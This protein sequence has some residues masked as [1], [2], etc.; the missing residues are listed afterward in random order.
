MPIITDIKK[1]ETYITKDHSSICELMH[2][3]QHGNTKQ[4]LAQAIVA[5]HSETQLHYHAVTEEL[6][7]I[8]QGS[9]LMTIDDDQFPVTIGDTVCI[10]PKSHHKIKN[11]DSVD[12]VFL[13]CCSP[14]YSHDDTF[15]INE[16]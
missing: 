14:A 8:T 10:P 15:I 6:Y 1:L 11:T 3:S 5:S 7:H 12:L 16:E 2:P 4:S 9:G 13:C